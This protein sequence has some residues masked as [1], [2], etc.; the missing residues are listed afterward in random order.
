MTEIQTKFDLMV[1]AVQIDRA[2]QQQHSQ[3]NASRLL[4]AILYYD[5]ELI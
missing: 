4:C 5:M 1:F 3:M 2:R